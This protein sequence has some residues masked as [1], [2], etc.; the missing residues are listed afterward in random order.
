MK[1]ETALE[2]KSLEAYPQKLHIITCAIFYE[3][4]HT[5]GSAQ[6]QGSGN[7]AHIS[8]EGEIE[9]FTAIFNARQGD[10][11]PCLVRNYHG[12]LKIVSDSAIT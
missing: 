4:K 6:V 9:E 11:S 10:S 7:K 1:E 8:M 5:I 12:I 3:W 2:T